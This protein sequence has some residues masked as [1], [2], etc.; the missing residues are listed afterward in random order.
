MMRDGLSTLG[1]M[2]LGIRPNLANRL[3]G[4]MFTVL[5]LQDLKYA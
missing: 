3:A 5:D 4:S 1:E 2:G